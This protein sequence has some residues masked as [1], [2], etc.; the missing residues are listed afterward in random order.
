MHNRI[1]KNSKTL[2]EEEKL[3]KFVK[4]EEFE[5]ERVIIAHG[6]KEFS[7]PT[8]SR[9]LDAKTSANLI[10]TATEYARIPL[11]VKNIITKSIEAKKTSTETDL[12]QLAREICQLINVKFPEPEMKSEKNNLIP[13]AEV[14]TFAACTLAAWPLAQ[15]N[16]DTLINTYFDSGSQNSPV[17]SYLNCAKK[18]LKNTKA[19][20]SDFSENTLEHYKNCIKALA[21]I[22]KEKEMQESP[23]SK[24]FFAAKQKIDFVNISDSIDTIYKKIEEGKMQIRTVTATP[25]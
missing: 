18:C 11:F 10:E 9:T 13:A 12:E 6:L 2:A 24:S 5:I 19:Q 25:V 21:S 16:F 20:V 14:F 15:S 17:N 7:L 1:I 3:R 8:H 22:W 4:Y 23:H